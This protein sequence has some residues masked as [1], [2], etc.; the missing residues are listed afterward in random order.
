MTMT[1]A[2]DRA[3]CHIAPT[4]KWI[5]AKDQP[6][7]IDVH[8][9]VLLDTEPPAAIKELSAALGNDAVVRENG[10]LR[11]ADHPAYLIV[12]SGSHDSV[13]GGTML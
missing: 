11:V 8:L 13:G 9:S 6:Y 4:S 10:W 3:F 1:V 7:V 12:V 2:V 5:M